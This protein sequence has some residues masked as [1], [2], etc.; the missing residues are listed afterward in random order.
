M[1]LQTTVGE[2]IA[3]INWGDGSVNQ[4]IVPFVTSEDVT[5]IRRRTV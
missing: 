1:P 5:I 2:Y 3:T 4:N